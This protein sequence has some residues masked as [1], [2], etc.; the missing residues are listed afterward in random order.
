MALAIR[1]AWALVA[2]IALTVALM[3]VFRNDV[4]GSWARRH[5]GAREA[6]EQG[7]REG[8]SRAG[9]VPPAF[10]PVGATMLVVA[11]M[12]VWVLTIFFRE[13]RRWGQIGLTGLVAVS[14]F[15]SV[16]LGLLLDPPPVFV[17]IAV[18]SLLVEGV[19]VVALWHPD[20]LRYLA[21]P[22]VTARRRGGRG[23][24]LRRPDAARPPEGVA[25]HEREGGH[26]H[27][28]HQQGVEQDADA[29][30]HAE[31]REHDQ[32]QHAEHREDGREQDPGAGDDASGGR[33]AAQHP[34]PA[35]VAER[36]LAGPRHQEDVVVD[37]QR[38]EEHE[39]E[40]D[41]VVV[42]ALEAQQVGEDE[43]GQ[44][45][46]GDVRR[47]D[48]R[49]E[50]DRR[51]HGSQQKDQRQQHQDEDEREDHAPVVGGG[52][53]RVDRLGLRPGGVGVGD[54]GHR[55]AHG[56]DGAARLRRARACFK[57]DVEGGD[58]RCV[59][60]TAYVG[61]AGDL[62]QRL[63]DAGRCPRSW[64]R[65]WG[66]RCPRGTTRRPVRSR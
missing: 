37:A 60:G 24:S 42:D 20:T 32:R 50:Q 21:G 59:G 22:S 64:P 33:E 55:L 62:R 8:L 45:E 15:A 4:I 25:E 3:A 12:L 26:Q 47:D 63:V 18:V 27:G 39:R 2:V 36:L 51:D 44:A 38:D 58:A 66:R 43:P 46:A 19:L 34:F 10:L 65:A 16:D 52:R 5:E 14:V 31:L 57:H 61:H 53:A 41:R 40:Q 11:A 54:A 29:D 49:H 35:A 56:G 30:D 1:A 17:V 13:G 28:P 23:L 7:G 9:F 6:F 48:G